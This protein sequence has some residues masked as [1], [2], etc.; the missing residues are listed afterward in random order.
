MFDFHCAECSRRQVLFASQVQQV[1]S[2]DQGV[3]VIVRCWCGGL[4]AIR[5]GAKA[6]A[7]PTER[8]AL[9]LAS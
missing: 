2:D 9:D 3:V 4:G 1:I 7:G 8:H 5:T 6:H